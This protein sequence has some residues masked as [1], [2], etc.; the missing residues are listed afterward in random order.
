LHF[1]P[2]F[3]SFFG[4]WKIFPPAFPPFFTFHLHFPV[5]FPLFFQK[6]SFSFF[7]ISFFLFDTI[8]ISVLPRHE[9]GP[10]ESI[11]CG[12]EGVPR[13]AGGRFRV[14]QFWEKNRLSGAVVNPMCNVCTMSYFIL[15]IAPTPIGEKSP[16]P[17]L[18]FPNHEFPNN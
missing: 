2:I 14:H 6:K 17:V 7:Y 8:C 3:P 12:A 4:G 10:T 5:F 16:S 18:R 1:T 15:L 13:G 11:G 9:R